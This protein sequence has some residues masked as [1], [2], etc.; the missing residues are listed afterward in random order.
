MKN[1]L[2]IV[3]L[4][5]FTVHFSN[6]QTSKK[7][8][9][10]YYNGEK[11]PLQINTKSISLTLKGNNAK[12][13][14]LANGGVLEKGEKDNIQNFINSSN[15]RVN[16]HESAYNVDLKLGENKRMSDS[17]YYQIISDY[18]N[19]EN[20]IMASP[21]FLS[22]GKELGLTSNF[23][24]KLNNSSDLKLLN[25]LAKKNKVEVLG[26]DKFMPLW[27]TISVTKKTGKN[28]LQM[29]NVFFE[30]GLFEA[31]EPEF[32]MSGLLTRFYDDSAK[33]IEETDPK[34]KVKGGISDRYF[35][36]QWYLKNRGQLLR[37]GEP[38]IGS[39][40]AT[41]DIKATKGIDIR[42][43][44]AWGVSKGK[45]I[46]VAVFDLGIEKEH[47]D[48]IKNLHPKSFDADSFKSPS[49][50]LGGLGSF[51][52][53]ENVSGIIGATANKRGI[54]G[55]APN[56]KLM[57]IS[58]GFTEQ[59]TTGI[60]KLSAGINWAWKNGADVIN[61][62]W[63]STY[64]SKMLDDA[65]K[66]ALTKG[67]NGKGC[68]VVFA[69]GNFGKEV[70]YPANSNPDILAVGSIDA[71]GKQ[72]TFSGFGK[73][74]DLV[75]P[76][77]YMVT[78]TKHNKKQ[79]IGLGV[80]ENRVEMYGYT[81]NNGTDEFNGV[82]GFQDADFQV[83]GTSFAAPLVSGVA[84]LI[85]SVNPKLTAKEVNK[86]I[87]ST[88]RKVRGDLY[89]YKN[90]GFRP[91]GS[92]HQMMGYGLLDARAAVRKA[93]KSKTIRKGEIAI[94]NTIDLNAFT[95]NTFFNSKTENLNIKG[96]FEGTLIEI[97]D[98]SGRLIK[99]LKLDEGKTT[100]FNTS[101]LDRG[102]YII[103]ASHNGEIAVKKAI[104]Y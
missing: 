50:R 15:K 79:L 84:A 75:A 20:V 13:M 2:L 28:A 98:L 27:Y 101:K 3:I 93:R 31:S 29:A 5:V 46:N 22:K 19:L 73:S 10:Y 6:S 82:N 100:S 102:I 71:N 11:V 54:R 4:L 78:T 83:V 49:K 55:I 61:N 81:V 41:K 1:K 85:L 38:K 65:I 12:A 34:N 8:N 58:N 47:E 40:P 56:C 57:I 24:I 35:K 89:K 17:D 36:H 88:A 103:R 64:K 99:S 97:I 18:N 43:L 25:K 30:T 48:L 23:F 44:G 77:E 90:L 45:K 37:K 62:S 76:G 26:S 51:N 9:H 96:D 60:R 104:I 80:P 32:K 69:T 39:L 66:N 86:I 33:N 91:N 59:N 42:A 7:E 92:W 94:E 63:F 14:R 74:L 95:F 70:L 52:H 21:N 72:S 16:T 53:G 67:R 87:E 68:A